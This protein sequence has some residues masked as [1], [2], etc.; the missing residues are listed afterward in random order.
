MVYEG[1]V[2]YTHVCICLNKNVIQKELNRAEYMPLSLHQ[3]L[4]THLSAHSYICPGKG[5]ELGTMI[6]YWAHQRRQGSQSGTKGYNDGLS[7][8]RMLVPLDAGFAAL[9]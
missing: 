9:V 6:S 2:V 8:K 4:T 1:R 5:R 3:I 7:N